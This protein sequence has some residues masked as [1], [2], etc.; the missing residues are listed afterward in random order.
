MGN[1]VT[2]TILSL[3]G[4]VLPEKLPLVTNGDIDMCWIWVM[5]TAQFKAV[6]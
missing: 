2:R 1:L 4:R 3:R 6:G 5:P